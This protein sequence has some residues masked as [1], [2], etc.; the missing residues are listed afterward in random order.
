MGLSGSR[1][2]STYRNFSL[3]SQKIKKTFL[4]FLRNI[5]HH[6]SSILSGNEAASMGMSS[7]VEMGFGRKMARSASAGTGI[8]N[9]LAVG[10]HTCQHH[11]N[12][13]H[14]V[15]L[16]RQHP[17]DKNRTSLRKKIFTFEVLL[18]K[19]RKF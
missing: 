19:S 17:R 12:N 4:F 16:I 10:A 2:V 18:A 14:V 3:T 7:G 5:S 11:K 13:N 6:R 1:N 8:N 15:S 9:F